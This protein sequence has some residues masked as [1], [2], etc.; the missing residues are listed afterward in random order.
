MSKIRPRGPEVPITPGSLHPSRSLVLVR[1]QVRTSP[2]DAPPSCVRRACP[3]TEPTPVIFDM[4]RSRDATSTRR[5]PVPP[6]PK[7]RAGPGSL[8]AC[9]SSRGRYYPNQSKPL[10]ASCR[11][12]LSSSFCLACL[13]MMMMLTTTKMGS[14][15]AVKGGRC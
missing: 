12:L 11:L 6:P 4:V 3:E 2:V 1:V 8:A 14:G 10:W 9:R 7:R 15:D 5:Y 13:R